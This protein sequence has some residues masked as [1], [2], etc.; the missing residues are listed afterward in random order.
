MIRWYSKTI[1]NPSY[2]VI[3]FLHGFMGSHHDWLPV[4]QRLSTE[5][6]CLILDLPGHGRTKAALASDYTM[7]STAN[8]LIEYLESKKINRSILL[9]YSMGGRLALYLTVQY[10]QFFQK[11]VLESASP[12]LENK[13]ERL[14]RQKHDQQLAEELSRIPAE[15]FLEKWY[16]VPLFA[17]LR[18]HP[19]FDSLIANRLKYKNVNWPASLRGMGLGEQRSL[20][21]KVKQIAVPVLVLAGEKDEK[22]RYISLKMK[23][24]NPRISLS[25][26]PEC[27]HNIHFEDE[28]RFYLEL[29]KFVKS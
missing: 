19:R 23:E 7:S 12:G 26:I 27:G 16:S 11:V 5:F 10:P 4:C 25:F 14:I 21:D 3:V 9:G 1:G 2:P 8:S 17:T 22:Y 6:R 20:W 18:N 24:Y 13:Q 15:E 29:I 28:E